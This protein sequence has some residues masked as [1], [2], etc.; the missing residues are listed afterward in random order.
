MS[1]PAATSIARRLLG[2]DDALARFAS[3]RSD[4]QCIGIYIADLLKPAKPRKS[5]LELM[6]QAIGR[7]LATVDQMLEGEGR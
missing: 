7:Q 1:A 5:T 2:Q 6:R 4:H 3:L